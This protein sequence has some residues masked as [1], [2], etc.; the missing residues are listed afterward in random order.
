MPSWIYL[1][2]CNFLWAGN[3]VFG[4]IAVTEF[5]PVWITIL[6]WL[7]AALIL[8]PIGLCCEKFSLKKLECKTW[9]LLFL[10]G[11]FG[12]ALFALLTY[13]ALEYT[14]S[15]NAS[16]LNAMTPAI[17]MALSNIFMNMPVS[18][19]QIIGLLLGFV[20]VAVIITQ[21]NLAQ[22]L[23]LNFNKGDL[24]MLAAD[25][26]WVLFTIISK[27]I[28]YLPPIT[29]TAISSVFGII[30]MIP[31]A[32]LEPFDVSNITSKGVGSILY[33]GVG[34]SVCAF[35]LW[36]AALRIVDVTVAGISLNLIPVY[37]V[38]I[39]VC[40]GYPFKGTQLWG[41]ILVF[42][43]MALISLPQSTLC[44]SIRGKIS[45]VALK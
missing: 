42:W 41:G 39:T 17:A 5:S 16:L 11:L 1:L 25:F 10:M 20:G 14:S 45:R 2:I 38:F 4:K 35:A 23:A 40:M 7:L 18:R 31:F 6:R 34:A 27:K 43:G 36:N 24:S 3:F 13:S 22:M 19:R 28:S 33:I 30:V 21:G 26:C 29:T 8:F 12:V 15:V 32:L 37:T 9:F 44:N